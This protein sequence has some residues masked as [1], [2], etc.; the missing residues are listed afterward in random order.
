M[1][2]S[3][4]ID[5]AGAQIGISVEPL[6]QLAQQTPA[7]QSTPSSLNTFVEYTQKMLENFF[8]YA[9]SFAIAQKIKQWHYRKTEKIPLNLVWDLSAFASDSVLTTVRSRSL[10]RDAV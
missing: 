6:D 1:D 10:S 7:S 8:N 5:K 9:S 4:V 3:T 2:A